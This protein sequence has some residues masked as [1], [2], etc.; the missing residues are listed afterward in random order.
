MNYL[1]IF[2][3]LVFIFLVFLFYYKY[4]PF[5]INKSGDMKIIEILLRQSARYSIAA[6]QDKSLFIAILHANYGAGYWWALKDIVPTD[7]ISR[8]AGVPYETIEKQVLS[9]QD[10]FTKKLIQTCSGIRSGFSETELN[11]YNVLIHL[12]GYS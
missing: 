11:K 8:V 3:G 5:E 7:V 9:I 4:L 1:S 2:I 12:A 10:I 6:L